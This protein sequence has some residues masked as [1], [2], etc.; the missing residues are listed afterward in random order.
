[1]GSTP[2][3]Q[4]A[5][6]GRAGAV[7]TLL[8]RGADPAIKTK[9]GKTALD[10]AI[11]NGQKDCVE[12]LQR[13]QTLGRERT[14]MGIAIRVYSRSFAAKVFSRSSRRGTRRSSGSC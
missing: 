7:E 6:W 11:E 2:L 5:S 13:R 14:Q 1:M 8:H 3:H 4:A 9:A 10:L 12:I